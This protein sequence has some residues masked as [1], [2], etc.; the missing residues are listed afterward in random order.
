MIAGAPF[1]AAGIALLALRWQ[2]VWAGVAALVVALAGALLWPELGIGGLGGGLWEAVGTVGGVVYV[3]AG[4][5]L[6]YNVLHEGGAIERVSN[7]LTR[8]EPEKEALA[9]VVVV[10]AAPFFESVTGFGVAVVIS[11]PILLGAGFDAVRAATLAS[12]GQLTVPWGALGVGTVIGANLSGVSFGALSNASALLSLPLFPVYGL[13]AVALAGGWSGLRHHGLEAMLVSAVAGIGVLAS[14]LYLAPE[15][16]GAIGGLA[17]VGAFLIP[18]VQRLRETPVPFRDL[19]PYGLLL[20]L[21]AISSGSDA[22]RDALGSL[23]P[24]FDGPGPWLFVSAAFAAVLLGLGSGEIAAFVKKTLRQWTPVAGAIL[25]FILAGQV[26]AVSGAAALLAGSAAGAFG[27]FY[28]AVAPVVGAL[29]GA[30]TGSNAGSN[31]L[32]MPLQA[33]AAETTGSSTLTLAALQNV[34]GSQANL[35]APQRIALAA[36]ATGLIGQE[37]KIVQAVAPPVVISLFILVAAGI[38]LA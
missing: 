34:A 21:L 4:G 23:G 18:R 35:L 16:A 14:S 22:A 13:A 26:V 10:G 24:L 8:V 7:F 3:L 1:V 17:A 12:W 6:L 32:F 9:L 29:G 28:P 25:T 15:L 37:A 19:A 11:A 5:L 2:A 31:A 36:T 27:G 38:I 20:A 30:L 33:G